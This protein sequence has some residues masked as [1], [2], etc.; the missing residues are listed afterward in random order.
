MSSNVVA[1]PQTVAAG[2]SKSARKKKAK[3]EAAATL[4]VP[5]TEKITS[6]HGSDEAGKINGVDSSGENSY[7]KEL[8]KWVALARVLAVLEI[9]NTDNRR[10]GTF[11]TSTRSL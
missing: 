7:I 2:E 4:A 10:T 6:E 5:S 3:A 8:Q 1:N 11:V 9:L